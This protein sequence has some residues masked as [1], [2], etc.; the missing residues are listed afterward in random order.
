VRLQKCC[1]T[2]AGGGSYGLTE[3]HIMHGEFTLENPDRST[4]LM[5][6]IRDMIQAVSTLARD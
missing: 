5:S 4:C 6:Y 2:G 3:P 1:E